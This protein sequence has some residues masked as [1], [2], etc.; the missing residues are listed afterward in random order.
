M[1]TSKMNLKQLRQWMD[2]NGY[3]Y[4]ENETVA[5]L[6]AVVKSIVASQKKDAEFE[7]EFKEWCYGGKK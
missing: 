3:E 2:N 5:E 4:E 7:I 6:R 1:D